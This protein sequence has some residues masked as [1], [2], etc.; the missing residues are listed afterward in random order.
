MAT[1]NFQPVRVIARVLLLTE[2]RVQQ[3]AAEG[4]IPKASRGQYDFIESVRGYIRHLREQI[5]PGR[6]NKVTILDDERARLTRARASIAELDERERREELVPAVQIEKFL[7]SILSRVRQGVLTLPSRAA[8][9][10]HDAKT[11]QQVERI[12]LTCCQEVLEEISKTR[13]DFKADAQGVAGTR[14]DR[15][16]VVP[17]SPTTT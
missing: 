12:I 9:K 7:Q 2:R 14:A 6:S 4:V 10:A 1:G 3:L 15:D 8:P 17:D 5:E 11:I 16:G 13:L